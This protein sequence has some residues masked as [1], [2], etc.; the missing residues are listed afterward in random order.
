MSK[1]SVTTRSSKQQKTI[2]KR[3]ATRVND[4]TLNPF[5]GALRI[6]LDTDVQHL[7]DDNVNELK[8][9]SR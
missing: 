1:D 8:N 9:R 7:P 6:W 3:K 4:K 5:D 2:K